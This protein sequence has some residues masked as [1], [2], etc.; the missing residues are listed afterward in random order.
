MH[1]AL[2]TLHGLRF[3]GAESR[4]HYAG[5]GLAAERAANTKRAGCGLEEGM[6]LPKTKS[7][8]LV[9]NYEIN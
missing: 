9:F 4:K 8:L 1:R 3:G 5:Y 2:Q 7:N 6:R